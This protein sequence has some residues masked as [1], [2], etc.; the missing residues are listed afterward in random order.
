MNP[1][2]DSE[3]TPTD[4][5]LFS[6]P[7]LAFTTLFEVIGDKL[8]DILLFSRKHWILLSITAALIYSL[9][10]FPGLHKPR[11]IIYFALYWILLGVASSIG[12]GTGLHTFVLYLGPHIAKV[13]MTATECGY[14]PDMV[15]SR[16]AFDHFKECT[17]IWLVL[18]RAQDQRDQFPDNTPGSAGRG[19]PLG[20]RNSPR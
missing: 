18:F 4:V 12:L 20:I 14:V 17:R 9:Y 11:E 16:W 8:K 15:P 2:D 1:I 5:T 3:I 7:K 13:A 6:H 19:L 10:A